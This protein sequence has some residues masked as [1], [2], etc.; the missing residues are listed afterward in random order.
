MTE[1]KE[2]QTIYAFVKKYRAEKD[3]Q[4][5]PGHKFE[6][7]CIIMGEGRNLLY[8]QLVATSEGTGSW[9]ELQHSDIRQLVLKEI[10]KKQTKTLKTA[11]SC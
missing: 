10:E 2:M 11:N 4:P 5:I 6:P 8:C 9:R 1:E 3:I 7:S